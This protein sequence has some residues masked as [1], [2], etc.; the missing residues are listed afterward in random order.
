MKIV[1]TLRE[2][3]IG[4]KDFPSAVRGRYGHHV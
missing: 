2:D 4:L 3:L 1:F